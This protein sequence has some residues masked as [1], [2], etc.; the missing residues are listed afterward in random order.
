MEGKKEQ[1]KTAAEKRGSE[2]SNGKICPLCALAEIELLRVE[3]QQTEGDLGV[4]GLR[5]L[6]T[7]FPIQKIQTE[8]KAAC[9]PPLRESAQLGL[10]QLSFFTR[11]TV[12]LHCPGAS[13]AFGEREACQPS[14]QTQ[15]L[16]KRQN[17]LKSLHE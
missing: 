12:C 8:I 17:Q 7:S 11:K 15:R 10:P 9:A 13:R 4:G 2:D 5:I 16:V 1:R 6:S 14:D 3:R